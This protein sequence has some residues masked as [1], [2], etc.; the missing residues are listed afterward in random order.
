MNIIEKLRINILYF[1]TSLPFVIIVYEILMTITLGNRGYL[2]LLLG[3]LGFVP[4]V[5]FVSD[6]ILFSETSKNIIAAVC[7]LGLC[8]GIGYGVY[9]GITK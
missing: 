2:V 6:I 9:K 3:Q 1:F 4:I 8:G 5:I 7:L